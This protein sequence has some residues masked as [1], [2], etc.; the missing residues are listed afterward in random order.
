MQA[1]FP[2]MY[3]RR[4]NKLDKNMQQ[5]KT[6]MSY[7]NSLPKIFRTIPKPIYNMHSRTGLKV[8]SRLRLRLSHLNE[9]KFNHN[10]RDCLNPLCPLVWK[11]SRLPNIRKLLFHELQPVDE[12]I[13]KSDPHITK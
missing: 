3:N 8:F 9:N 12:N 2:F 7:R 5:S 11:F 1:F 13:L 10:F 4:I 6:A